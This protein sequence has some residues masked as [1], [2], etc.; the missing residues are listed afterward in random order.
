MFRMQLSWASV[1][2]TRGTYKWTRYDRIFEMAARRGISVMPVLLGSPDW[3]KHQACNYCS[4]AQWPPMTTSQRSAYYRFAEAAARRYGRNGTFWQGKTDLA[5]STR[6]RYW[7]VWNEPNLGNYWNGRPSPRQYALM[8][9]GTSDALHRGDANAS[10]VAAG[11]PWSSSSNISPPDFLRT[12]FLYRPELRSKISTVAIHPYDASPDGVIE[13]VRL[14]RRALAGTEG[15][16]K[17][18]WLTEFGWAT[19]PRD[20]R[21]FTISEYGQGRNL[22]LTYNKLL[23]V[24]TQYRLKGAMWFNLWDLQNPDWWAERTGLWRANNTPKPSW[25]RLNCVTGTPLCRR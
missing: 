24:R 7:Q 12:M 14:T 20:S 9:L 4:K 23:A 21:G 2:S 11:L 15:R 13:G 19:G 18:I 1:E 5:T 25:F 8:L 3:V 22:E 16:Y 6:V 10:V 17:Y